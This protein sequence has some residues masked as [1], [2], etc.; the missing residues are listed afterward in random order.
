MIKKI[1]LQPPAK[2]FFK[3][4]RVSEKKRR[5][6]MRNYQCKKCKVLIQGDTQPSSRGCPSGDRHEW[7]DLYEVGNDNYQCKKCGVLVKSDTQPP[8][9][10]CP[11]GDRHEWNKL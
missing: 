3:K 2:R 4:N 7:Y 8:S 9:R 10:G 5:I 11:S 6:V 1:F